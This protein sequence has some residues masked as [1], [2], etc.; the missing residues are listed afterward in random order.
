M[1]S[2]LF[3]HFM[4]VNYMEDNSFTAFNILL[5]EHF[6]CFMALQNNPKIALI[7]PNIRLFAY[8]RTIILSS[9][10]IVQLFI[11]PPRL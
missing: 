8:N 5:L 3:I 9:A 10:E 11:F 4:P 6:G 1:L 2:H 7:M